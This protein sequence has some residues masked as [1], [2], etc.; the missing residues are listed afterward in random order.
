MAD[1]KSALRDTSMADVA[2]TGARV[3]RSAE[4]TLQGAVATG[5]K[6]VSDHTP[7]G[8]KQVYRDL[9]GYKNAP[10]PVTKRSQTGR[11]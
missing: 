1:L 6:F 8:V 5:R 7:E 2:N 3:M 9:R 10:P 11:R 4:N